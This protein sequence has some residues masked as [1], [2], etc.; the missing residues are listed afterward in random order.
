MY[1]GFAVEGI[2]VCPKN[3]SKFKFMFKFE[4]VRP[5]AKGVKGPDSVASVLSRA[6]ISVQVYGAP[7]SGDIDASL[8]SAAIKSTSV[9]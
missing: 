4:S 1:T 5:F 7:S 3:F 8:H 9:V 6:A 2:L